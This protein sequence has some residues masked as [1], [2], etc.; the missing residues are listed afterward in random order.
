MPYTV[1]AHTAHQQKIIDRRQSNQQRLRLAMPLQ[2]WPTK[3]PTRPPQ[4]PTPSP[5]ASL[6]L[7]VACHGVCVGVCVCMCVCWCVCV[8]GGSPTPTVN[9]STCC[10][11]SAH[12]NDKALQ[13]VFTP[14]HRRSFQQHHE[15]DLAG[16]SPT[17]KARHS[18]LSSAS[19]ARSKFSTSID[20]KGSASDTPFSAHAVA[21]HHVA[22]ST[23][24]IE[25][26]KAAQP[27]K[28]AE[29]PKPTEGSS[30]ASDAPAAPM[31][32]HQR[33]ERGRRRQHASDIARL[34][35]QSIHYVAKASVMRL[36]VWAD[37]CGGIC[38]GVDVSH[39]CLMQNVH[40]KCIKFDSRKHQCI[41]LWAVSRP[42]QQQHV[43]PVCAT[44]ATT[45]RCVC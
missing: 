22:E 39:G 17:A 25:E 6:P 11:C 24:T 36:Q 5:M 10:A 8:N 38:C 20:G 18:W 42:Q 37:L 4:W 27:P 40:N 28:A 29:A 33:R 35:F 21:E 7:L 13:C 14:T 32:P 34:P 41:N 16:T 1:H 43:H 12:L 26:V 31:A 15:D 23:K 3:L 19:S 2:T 9:T 45:S 44:T 30:I